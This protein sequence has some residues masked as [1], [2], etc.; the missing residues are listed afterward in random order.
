MSLQCKIHKIVKHRLILTKNML[1]K[2]E[3]SVFVKEYCMTILHMPSSISVVNPAFS[4]LSA[5]SSCNTM[6]VL[7]PSFL[8]VQQS[9]THCLMIQTMQLMGQC[10]FTRVRKCICLP[11][12]SILWYIT[13]LHKSA[14][15]YLLYI[16]QVIKQK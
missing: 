16:R 15:S 7:V 1:G 4:K 5:A 12:D 10:G 9:G 2:R 14:S 11:G 13:V 8:L 3:N 6:L